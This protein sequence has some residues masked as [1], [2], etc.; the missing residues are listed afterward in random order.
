MNTLQNADT[1]FYI[2]SIAVIL[3]TI[4]VIML[5]AYAIKIAQMVSAITKTIQRE[6][7]RVTEDIAEF[8]ERVREEGVKVSSFWRFMTGFF[9]NRFADRVGGKTKTGKTK[10]ERSE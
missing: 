2:T 7:E 8:R 6:S 9:L 10:R 3:V 4:L 1:F 5:L